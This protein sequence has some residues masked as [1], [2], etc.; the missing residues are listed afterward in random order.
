M[1]TTC[2]QLPLP[3]PICPGPSS[4]K[5]FASHKPKSIART[6]SAVSD[7]WSNDGTE[8]EWSAAQAL[9][10]LLGA[11]AQGSAQV[12]PALKLSVRLPMQP[13][14]PA[15]LRKQRTTN[16][17]SDTPCFLLPQSSIEGLT[18]LQ[19]LKASAAIQKLE[20]IFYNALGQK[21]RVGYNSGTDEISIT[22]P[23][24]ADGEPEQP[25]GDGTDCDLAAEETRAIIVQTMLGLFA[26]QAEI[27]K[28]WKSR[29]ADTDDSLL[30]DSGSHEPLLANQCLIWFAAQTGVGIVDRRVN[31][32]NQTLRLTVASAANNTQGRV[33]RVHYT[34]DHRELFQYH[35]SY[36]MLT[37]REMIGQECRYSEAVRQRQHE[38]FTSMLLDEIWIEVN[39]RNYFPTSDLKA[40][41][42]DMLRAYLH[43]A[44]DARRLSATFTPS[45]PLRLYLHGT[46]GVGK[47]SFTST[48]AAALQTVLQ[49]FITPTRRVDLVKCPLNAVTPDNLRAMLHVQGI[50]DWSIERVLEQ[51]IRRGD[52]ATFHLEEAPED[53]ALQAQLFS[54][55]EG[56]VVSLLSKYPNSRGNLI[57]VAVSNYPPADAVAAD[58]T[59]LK[60]APPDKAWQLAWCANM[61]RR[62]LAAAAGIPAG[63]IAT[64]LDA[65][66][67]YSADM[68]PLE[69]WRRCVA[70]HIAEHI[71]QR[72]S[73]SDLHRSTA[74]VRLAFAPHHCA[75]ERNLRVTVGLGLCSSH[76][77]VEVSP[78][79][80]ESFNLS[81]QDG[82][83]YHNEQKVAPRGEAASQLSALGTQPMHRAD[84]T[85]TVAMLAAEYVAPAVFILTGSAAAQHR[86]AA[87]LAEY[88]RRVCDPE[89]AQE[90]V[91]ITCMED[92][93]LIFG[94]PSDV[95]GGLCKFIDDVTNPAEVANTAVQ[96][97][98]RRF[99]LITA[100][101]N[102][103]GQYILREMLEGNTSRTHRHVARKDRTAF[104]VIVPEGC[105]LRPETRSRAHAVL[106][107]EEPCAFAA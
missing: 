71:K 23:L 44:V 28:L 63:N 78:A 29:V 70:F 77:N 47:S 8:T 61:L 12:L 65:P 83:F 42:T 21:P 17:D 76:R 69:V 15:T 56:M 46:A 54:L 59:T 31:L 67:V 66:P 74:T 79:I 60:M 16:S 85:T 81:T 100:T 97:R 82:F 34:D 10:H 2:H 26:D 75:S 105:A 91:S 72:V 49:T 30:L 40:L 57:F 32:V 37:G 107:C 89:L 48:I 52:V 92:K 101:A 64:A 106:H 87:A 58:Y 4:R 102:E 38:Q 98:P 73:P 99:A 104:I 90:H 22:V 88:I 25:V 94:K 3:T 7:V 43:S 55:I 86:T 50:S 36:F 35:G 5:D 1:S 45:A 93:S 20:A 62:S 39:R 24:E 41:T 68:R 53:P 14:S 80:Y 13:L 96:G 19:E 18:S 95:R 33:N 9:E 6:D 27:E 11:T 84:V 103:D 51:T